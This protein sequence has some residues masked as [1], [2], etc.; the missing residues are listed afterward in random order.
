[1]EEEEE[2]R[3]FEGIG[4]WKGKRYRGNG[5]GK[6]EGG[7]WKRKRKD[8]KAPLMRGLDKK[9]DNEFFSCNQISLVKGERDICIEARNRMSFDMLYI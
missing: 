8:G 6:V 7:R 2:A 1:M 4:E 3:G 5:K 9:F